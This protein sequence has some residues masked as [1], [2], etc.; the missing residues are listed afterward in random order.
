MSDINVTIEKDNDIDVSIDSVFVVQKEEVEL[1]FNAT[2]SEQEFIPESGTVY[3]KVTQNAIENLVPINV[4]LGV[5][6]AGVTGNLEPDKPDQSKTAYPSTEQQII[7]ADTGYELAQ[8]TIEPMVLNPL[9]ITPT[10]EQQTFSPSEGVDGYSSVDISAV[11]NS[12]DSNIQSA[13]IK[14]GI[15]ILG[16]LGTAEVGGGLYQRPE[17]WLPEPTFNETVDEIYILL[18]IY[19]QD[20]T[21]NNCPLNVWFSNGNCYV[22]WGDG[23]V[24]EQITSNTQFNHTYKYG[25]ISESAYCT[26]R[27][28]K[29]VWC[30]IYGDIGTTIVDHL[31][32]QTYTPA[33]YADFLEIYGNV[34][35]LNKGNITCNQSTSV[36]RYQYYL[37]IY[38][39]TAKNNGSLGGAQYRFNGMGGLKEIYLNGTITNGTYM[40]TGI[41]GTVRKIYIKTLNASSMQMSYIFNGCWNGD[42]VIVDNMP[43]APASSYSALFDSRYFVPKIIK[44]INLVGLTSVSTA[45]I[46]YVYRLKELTLPGFNQTFNLVGTDM[47]ATAL[48]ALF[49]SLGTVVSKTIRIDRAPGALTCDKTIATA[50][51]W[52]VVG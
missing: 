16:V 11:T 38:K 50:K 13:N 14:K 49:E 43:I 28:Y 31:F 17:C 3:S 10:I 51:G 7:T 33:T 9:S 24:V 52:T 46:V 34:T 25:D 47:D 37:E 22:D 4:R 29:M 40:T 18:A 23:S 12:I 32:N 41:A 35:S 44:G 39:M 27:G 5:E 21:Y 30:R 15:S 48:N 42:S 8:V 2:A 26:E 45:G 19:N 20:D 6:I 1:T 36:Q